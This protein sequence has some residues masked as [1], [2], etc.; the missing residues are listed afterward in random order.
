MMNLRR[1]RKNQMKGLL[2]IKMRVLLRTTIKFSKSW[3]LIMAMQISWQIV[4][5]THL[6]N[7]LKKARVNT[8]KI[9]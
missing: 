4:S 5:K 1:V 6:L 7:L 2:M 9:R 3:M 8:P